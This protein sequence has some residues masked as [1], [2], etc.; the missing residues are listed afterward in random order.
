MHQARQVQGLPDAVTSARQW[1]L[2]GISVPQ[3]RSALHE[4]AELTTIRNCCVLQ[5]EA[6]EE[7]TAAAEET[8]GFLTALQHVVVPEA[9]TLFLADPTS[10]RHHLQLLLLQLAVYNR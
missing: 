2:L 4:L 7:E 10:V 1:P 6:E 8:A 3:V 5:E 9:A